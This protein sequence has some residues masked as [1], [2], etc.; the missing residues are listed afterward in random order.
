MFLEQVK[1]LSNVNFFHVFLLEARVARKS[2]VT[3][4]SLLVGHLQ[5]GLDEFFVGQEQR[6]GDRA[7]FLRF[8]KRNLA[9]GLSHGKQN[10][11][12][13]SPLIKSGAVCKLTDQPEMIL[14]G[15]DL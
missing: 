11:Q 4:G 9:V 15:I 10:L 5:F 2:L 12:E 6:I 7:N 1:F 13:T 3:W 14:A 8:G